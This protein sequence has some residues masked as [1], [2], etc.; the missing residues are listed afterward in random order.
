[1][2]SSVASEIEVVLAKEEHVQVAA[3]LY[4]EA[5]REFY[6]S[7]DEA[8]AAVSEKQKN[9]TLWVALLGGRVVGTFGYIRGW[10]HNVNYLNGIVV[11]PEYRELGIG[12][13][14]LQKFIEICKKEQ[15]S[16]DYAITSTRI[17]NKASIS[18]S[19]R[20]GFEECGVIKGLHFGIDE[21]FFRIKVR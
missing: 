5:F 17:N 13:K 1:M 4:F 7:K 9:R 8:V 11:L 6:R 10:S 3:L 21:V 2:G 14:M 15:M 18:I 12:S 16:Q 19:K 20:M